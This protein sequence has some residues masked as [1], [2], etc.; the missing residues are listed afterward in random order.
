[1]VSCFPICPN[2]LLARAIIFWLSGGYR[3]QFIDWRLHLSSELRTL[4]R[5]IFE[6][7][8]FIDRF[9]WLIVE[10]AKGRPTVFAK[11]VGIPAGTLYGYIDG[12]LP[13]PEYLIR[14]H[15]VFGVN[16]NWLLK[17]EGEPFLKPKDESGEPQQG[18]TDSIETSL[19]EILKL[20]EKV[21]TSGNRQAMDALEKNIRYFAHAVEV[22]RK[23]ESM[24]DRLKAIE[25]RL[26]RKVS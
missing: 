21:L 11:L 7:S 1:M 9:S 3:C 15:E 12:K 23:L 8:S 20:A 17:G 6:N 25:D 5:K 4:S 24:D 22:E 19:T 13:T 10:K 16:I 18:I 14:I 26:E 2:F